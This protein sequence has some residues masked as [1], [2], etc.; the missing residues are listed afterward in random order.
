MKALAEKFVLIVGIGTVIL[1]AMILLPKFDTPLADSLGSGIA[2][3][4]H[5]LL[6]AVAI[7]F[8]LVI[9]I[10]AAVAVVKIKHMSTTHVIY[11]PKDNRPVRAVIHKG[12]VVQLA[13]GGADLLE[14]MKIHQQQAI[15]MQQHWK[16]IATA[17]TTMKKFMDE[18][19]LDDEED[20]DGIVDGTIDGTVNTTKLL[21]GPSPNT[22]HKPDTIY[23]LSDQLKNQQTV[24]NEDE[25][26][27]GYAG[28]EI[29]RGPL[30]GE[31]GNMM[32][33]VFVS[34]N[35]GFGKS[36][37]AVYMHALN[38]LHGGKT[39]IIDPDADLK[40]SLSKRLGPL[41]V[42]P[43]LLCPIASTPEAAM[44]LLEI[45]EEEIEDP[46]PFPV[47]LLIDEFTMIMRSAAAKGRWMEVGKKLATIAEDWATRGRKRRRRVIVFGQ[48]TKATRAG[49]T[50]LR[51]CMTMI[52]FHLKKKRAAIVLE[53]EEAELAPML[54]TGQVIVI[55]ER[56][57]ESCYVMQLPFPDKESLEMIAQALI[58]MGRVQGE[59]QDLEN[60]RIESS[61]DPRSLSPQTAN[62]PQELQR[63]TRNTG[64][65]EMSA[66]Q[67]LERMGDSPET[68]PSYPLMNETQAAQF[69][70]L[71]PLHGLEKSLDQIKGCS[72][73]HREHA[74]ELIAKHNLQR[75]K[76]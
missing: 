60:T 58:E 32:D 52:C 16:M 22:D 73:K 14:A 45:A 11:D 44:Q 65:L 47:L 57:S 49:G 10:V 55:P 40:Q 30:F 72:H 75:R 31:E 38:V 15:H 54:K 25:S 26:I 67:P 6:I 5:D 63:A 56:A 34:G 53:K 29:I 12:Q 33:S 48:I 41:G 28:D 71:Y 7:V 50:E 18:Y 76:S 43:F 9:I 27:I 64:E 70:A 39:L 2:T 20:E 69:I 24:I 23:K 61:N 74:R 3:F 4:L 62:S 36:V 1:L 13:P 42:P 46:S 59:P 19:D 21:E 37:F 68:R 51:D 66:V 8:G 35:Q 17:T